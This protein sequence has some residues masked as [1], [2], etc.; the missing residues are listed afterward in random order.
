MEDF[1]RKLPL[2]GREEGE[3]LL[4]EGF[5]KHKISHFMENSKKSWGGARNYP[6]GTGVRVNLVCRIDPATMA[7]LEE[8]SAN[9]GFSKGKIIDDLVK[10]LG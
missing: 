9:T 3:S 1:H 4:P 2:T 8:I 10:N 6:K 7:R 5:C